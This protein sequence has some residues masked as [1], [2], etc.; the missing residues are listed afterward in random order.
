MRQHT[1]KLR[2]FRQNS[3]NI[4]LIDIIHN[5]NSVI[6]RNNA[7]ESKRIGYFYALFYGRNGLKW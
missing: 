6:Q 3:N 5:C 7:I 2:Y 1:K 4:Y